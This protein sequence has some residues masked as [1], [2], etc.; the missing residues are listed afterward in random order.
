MDHPEL[1]RLRQCLEA[2][3]T[4]SRSLRGFPGPDERAN[5]F[6]ALADVAIAWPAFEFTL[7]EA[8]RA[9]YAGRTASVMARIGDDL[10]Y[11]SGATDEAIAAFEAGLSMAPNHSES[12]KGIV[13]AY[14]QG[15]DRRPEKALPY[16]ERLAAS[17]P[18]Q[19]RNVRYIRSLIAG[20]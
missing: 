2:V 11:G 8:E 5:F 7:P 13:A 4:A 17:D 19:E 20:R 16:A 9:D 15:S 10:F 14:L 1:D 3:H 12:L 18:R 6:L